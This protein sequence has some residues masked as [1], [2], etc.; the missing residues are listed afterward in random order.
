MKGND[1]I[2]DIQKK[3]KEPELKYDLVIITEFL[4]IEKLIEI[5]ELCRAEKIDLF[6][7]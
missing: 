2:A 4:P 6:Y 7:L 3:L 5:D 1:I